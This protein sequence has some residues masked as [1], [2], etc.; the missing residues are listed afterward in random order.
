MLVTE[1]HLNE[2]L[3]IHDKYVS[4]GFL[5]RRGYAWRVHY[6]SIDDFLRFMNRKNT[7]QTT[8][9]RPE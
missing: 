2:N 4:T 6:N 9:V 7:F 5:I 8:F 3:T 1:T